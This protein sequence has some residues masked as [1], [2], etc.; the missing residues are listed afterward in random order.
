MQYQDKVYGEVEIT[1]PVLLDILNSA[2]M[3]RLKGVNQYGTWVLI[4]PEYNT[5]RFEHSVGVMILLKKLDADLKEQIAG[6]IHDVAHA[7][8]SHVVDYVF[9]REKN[10]DLHDDL[11]EEYV[12]KTDLPEI[13]SRYGYQWEELIDEKN[14]PLLEQPQPDLCG[15][16]VD[17]ILRDGLLLGTI[18]RNLLNAI[19]DS[20]AVIG[21][22]I[23][24]RDVHAARRMAGAAI[25]MGEN[26]WG[27]PTQS[28]IFLLLAK[29]MKR[30]ID[31]GAITRDDLWLTD[32]K[33]LRKL[34]F[35]EDEMILKN[36]SYL[37]PGFRVE[38]VDK[39]WDYHVF[40]KA[41]YI[42]PLVEVGE[43]IKKLSELDDF[44]KNRIAHYIEERKPGYKVKIIN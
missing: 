33:I 36:L 37:K 8:F 16:R 22:Q 20:L 9:G 44:F 21:G 6:L 10:Q 24:M 38:Q 39:N 18:D 17:Y 40:T 25:K 19:L 14:F 13:L 3:Q 27:C 5:N 26:F 23:V 2:A 29:A 12:A 7:A 4:N 1:E 32:D 43:E 34:Q 11:S 35:S 15:D 30:G 31:L 28:T 42:D 41:R